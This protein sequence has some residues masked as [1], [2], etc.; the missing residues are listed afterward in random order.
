MQRVT[1]A[2]Y[3]DILCVW[4]YVGQVRL[5]E[6]RRQFGAQIEVVPRFCSVF[7]DT[8]TK[9]G[10]GW[11]DRGG[12]EAY[13][14]HARSV[15]RRFGRDDLHPDVW[16]K[17][18]PATSMTAHAYVRAAGR[19]AAAE[20][21]SRML[22]LAWALRVAFFREGRD[23]ARLEVQEEVARGMDLPVEAIREELDAGRAWAALSADYDAA[24]AEGI[25]GSPT[26][27]LNERRQILYGNV[28]Y[29]VIEANVLELLREP[30]DRASWC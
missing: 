29:K 15:V 19:V 25:R 17:V 2:Y 20:G 24:A 7:A 23:V 1:I 28:G 3:S 10:L 12:S 13:A 27:V 30:G 4:A 11:K 5:D 14:E 26:Y 9:I 18:A 21:A 22:E 16:V 8:A 6:L